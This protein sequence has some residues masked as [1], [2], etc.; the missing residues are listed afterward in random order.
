MFGS[1]GTEL[2]GVQKL[3]TGLRDFFRNISVPLSLNVSL[4]SPY[5]RKTSAGRF[6]KKGLAHALPP[7][8][9]NITFAK[10]AIARFLYLVVIGFG[11][12]ENTALRIICS[13]PCHSGLPVQ[14]PME[15]SGCRTAFCLLVQ[16]NVHNKICFCKLREE[17]DIVT[18]QECVT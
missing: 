13:D 1:D 6:L 7:I 18:L 4:I 3:N 17:P 16:A 10:P 5:L 14:Y 8:K 12:F 15:R 2:I 11:F 9:Q